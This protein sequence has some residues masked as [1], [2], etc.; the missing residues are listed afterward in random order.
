MTASH[1]G[2]QEEGEV[3]EEE[4]EALKLRAMEGKYREIKSPSAVNTVAED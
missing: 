3:E 4:E 2:P 1:P